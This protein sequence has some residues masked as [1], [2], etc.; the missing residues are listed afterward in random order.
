MCDQMSSKYLTA[1]EE[2]GAFPS[3]Q[4][5]GN[6]NFEAFYVLPVRRE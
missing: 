4:L 3:G 5:S 1:I 6:E 2:A